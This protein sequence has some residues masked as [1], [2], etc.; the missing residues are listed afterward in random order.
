MWGRKPWAGRYGVGYPGVSGGVTI[1][2]GSPPRVTSDIRSQDALESQILSYN[3][4]RYYLFPLLLETLAPRVTDR[5]PRPLCN[6][7]FP[8]GNTPTPFLTGDTDRS[9]S[10]LFEKTRLA[11]V[12]TSARKQTS[13]S[14]RI[15]SFIRRRFPFQSRSGRGR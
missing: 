14:I 6:L 2:T 1:L 9:N 3:P 15:R 10:D 7:P 13:M 8:R 4:I 11:I 5:T 12:S